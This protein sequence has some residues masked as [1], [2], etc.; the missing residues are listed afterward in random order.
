MTKEQRIDN[1]MN[2]MLV[3]CKKAKEEKSVYEAILAS[4]YLGKLLEI[5][6]S[7]GGKYIKEI[8]DIA[9]EIENN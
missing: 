1:I 4:C 8:K 9:V 5:D 6:R 3:H 7:I 2:I